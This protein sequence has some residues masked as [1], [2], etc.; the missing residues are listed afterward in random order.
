MQ[1]GSGRRR[2]EINVCRV[3]IYIDLKLRISAARRYCAACNS[4]RRN[5]RDLAVARSDRSWVRRSPVRTDGPAKCAG[6]RASI[7]GSRS[8]P[9]APRNILADLTRDVLS[10]K[11]LAVSNTSPFCSPSGSSRQDAICSTKQVCEKWTLTFL[12]SPF[13]ALRFPFPVY[14]TIFPDR[15]SRESLGKWLQYSSF[16]CSYPS[17]W[18][19]NCEIPCKIP[20]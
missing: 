19:N 9:K 4:G 18:A 8:T 2:K 10:P 12:R 1:E 6:S 15:F 14:L 5:F 20:C 17:V 11:P 13:P 16:C 3:R 7:S